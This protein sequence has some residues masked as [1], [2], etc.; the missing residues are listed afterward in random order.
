MFYGTESANSGGFEEDTTSGGR[1]FPLHVGDAWEYKEFFDN[2]YY[3]REVVGDTLI[4][5]KVYADYRRFVALNGGPMVPDPFI[6]KE[7]VRFDTLSAFVYGWAPPI[8]EYNLF[9]AP[10][11]LDAD[12]GTMVFCPGTGAVADVTGGYDGVLVFGGE[13]PGTGE[14]TVYT[15]VKAY[16]EGAFVFRYGADHGEVYHESDAQLYGL[17]YSRVDGVEHGVPQYSTVSIDPPI[18]GVAEDEG[19]RI[20]PNPADRVLQVEILSRAPQMMLVHIFDLA[21]RL[22]HTTEGGFIRAGTTS[23]TLFV[24]GLSAGTYILRI[25]GDDGY[26]ETALFT[27][28]K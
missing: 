7:Y 10:C 14:D 25:S 15:A 4:E 23:L 27:K 8:G 13:E 20:W 28:L 1:Y 9:E 11:P 6:P 21:G 12:F 3:R 18:P 16:D 24:S 5:G 17:Y 22:V 26:R 19:S 2:T